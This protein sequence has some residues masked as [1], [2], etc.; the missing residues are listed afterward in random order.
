MRNDALFKPFWRELACIALM[1][2]GL[3]SVSMN[4][5]TEIVHVVG[6]CCRKTPWSPSG[7]LPITATAVGMLLR[8]CVSTTRCK[9]K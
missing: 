1:H 2:V 8:Y 3:A 7:Q 9:R 6:C 5:S 4:V